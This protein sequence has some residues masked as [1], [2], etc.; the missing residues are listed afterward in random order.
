MD[1]IEKLRKLVVVLEARASTAEVAIVS[2][3]ALANEYGGEMHQAGYIEERR[4]TFAEWLKYKTREGYDNGGQMISLSEFVAAEL[5]SVLEAV[6]A[7]NAGDRFNAGAMA[8]I[9]AAALRLGVNADYPMSSPPLLCLW[10][11]SRGEGV[12]V[13][14]DEYDSFVVAAYTEGEARRQHPSGHVW[15]GCAQEVVV[16][17]DQDWASGAWPIKPEDVT[18]KLIGIADQSL[19]PG[20]VLIASYNAG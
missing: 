2:L 7:I 12:H 15:N 3:A 6:A 4:E 5:R 19:A 20:A 8:A 1:E 14:Y 13:T 10:L 9:N 11:V 17:G 16:W 18:V